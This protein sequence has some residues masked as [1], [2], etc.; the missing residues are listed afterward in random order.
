MHGYNWHWEWKTPDEVF[1]STYDRIQRIAPDKPVLIG[2]TASTEQGGS[3]ATWITDLL[4]AQLPRRFPNVKG[5]TWFNKKDPG[6][7][8]DP[9]GWLL[10]SSTRALAAFKAAIAAP[11]FAGPSF[12]DLPGTTIQ[13]LSPLVKPT[14]GDGGGA[15]TPGSGGSRITA[16]EAALIAHSRL[17]AAPRGQVPATANKA[18]A[19][20][21][22]ADRLHRD[23]TRGRHQRPSTRA[24]DG[25]QRA[26]VRH[27]DPPA[28]PELQAHADASD[29]HRKGRRAETHLPR[30]CLA[31]AQPLDHTLGRDG[32]A[33]CAGATAPED[34]PQTRTRRAP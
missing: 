9:D 33:P 20:V 28:D 27:P 18:A 26:S 7:K 15:N 11:Y 1:G 13:P 29:E 25:R 16:R 21:P 24:P 2:E 31:P 17:R 5:V 30:V 8:E 32:G 3:K 6:I 14:P 23:A 4:S 22:P 34:S 19:A 12:R 10:D